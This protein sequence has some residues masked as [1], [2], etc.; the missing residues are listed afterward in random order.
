MQWRRR[1]VP[2][3][4]PSSVRPSESSPSCLKER[5]AGPD[6]F[7]SLSLTRPSPLPLRHLLTESDKCTNFGER[8]DLYLELL[9]L[10][11]W[12]EVLTEYPSLIDLHSVKAIFSLQPSAAEVVSDE[13]VSRSRKP[14]HL[15]G[16][17]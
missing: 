10:E 9:D 12:F 6:V 7:V 16:I 15:L 14:H 17:E 8:E 5:D 11:D 4:R 13:P 1:T 3:S 2:S